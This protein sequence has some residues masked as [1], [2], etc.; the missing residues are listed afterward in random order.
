MYTNVMP[1]IGTDPEFFIYRRTEE[2]LKLVPADKVLPSKE[3]KKHFSTGSVFFDGVQAEI[4]PHPDTC[5]ERLQSKIEYL[6]SNT[7]NYVDEKYATEYTPIRFCAYPSITVDIKELE[8]CDNECFRFGC[9]PSNSIYPMRKIKFP[10]GKTFPHRFAGGHIHIGFNTFNMMRE[11][12]DPDKLETFIKMCD[13]LAG[14]PATAMAY[15]DMEKLR[16]RYYGRAGEYRIQPHGI[17]YR[18]LSN[19]WLVSPA[20]ASLFTSFVREALRYTYGDAT[21]MWFDQVDIDEV[22]KII[23]KVDHKGARRICEDVI[24]PR[25]E[26]FVQRSTVPLSCENIRETVKHL[27]EY[28]YDS[29]FNPKGILNYWCLSNNTIFYGI[30]KFSRDIVKGEFTYDEVYNLGE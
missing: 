4:N 13:I 17:E 19:F 2:G 22:K 8:G 15:N 28:G 5:R 24:I 27:M 18:T 14:I 25:Y 29:V 30:N 9:A 11:M 10:D 21:T 6:F 7:V 26:R 1:D 20:M 16:R 23:N 3:E 12:R